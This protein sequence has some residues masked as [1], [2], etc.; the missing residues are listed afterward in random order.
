MAFG[1]QAQDDLGGGVNLRQAPVG[2]LR[3]GEP[4]WD[5]EGTPDVVPTATVN[6]EVEPRLDEGPHHHLLAAGAV[7]GASRVIETVIPGHKHDVV[8]F[9]AAPT[10]PA[11]QPGVASQLQIGCFLTQA[12]VS[13]NEFLGRGKDQIGQAGQGERDPLVVCGVSTAQ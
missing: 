10:D 9:G 8:P 12:A 3:S 11:M 6:L 4:A 1:L 13:R 5:M 2:H 7:G